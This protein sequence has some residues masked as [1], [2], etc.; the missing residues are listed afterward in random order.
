[1]PSIEDA[2]MKLKIAAR[3]SSLLVALAFPTLHTLAAAAPAV[4]EGRLTQVTTTFLQVDHARTYQFDPVSAV[5]FDWR[6]DALTCDTLVGIGYADRV[7]I[8]LR[9][10]VVQ[11]VDILELQ[12]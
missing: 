7:R 1:M 9:G 2:H 12:Q 5:C 8:T 3:L 4:V 10:N 11:R 6:G